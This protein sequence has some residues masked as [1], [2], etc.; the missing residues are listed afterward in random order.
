M[1]YRLRKGWSDEVRDVTIEPRFTSAL[2]LVSAGKADGA[3]EA[4]L[5]MLDYVRRYGTV[6]GMCLYELDGDWVPLRNRLAA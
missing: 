3:P 5:S 4:Q 1:S 2:G 6:M